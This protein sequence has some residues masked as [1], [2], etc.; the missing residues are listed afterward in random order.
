MR[1]KQKVCVE[2]WE[3]APQVNPEVPDL[4]AYGLCSS[5]YTVILAVIL[6]VPFRSKYLSSCNRRP[7]L[8]KLRLAIAHYGVFFALVYFWRHPLG[9][10]RGYI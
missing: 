6:N 10:T 2:R 9:R 3:L 8:L 1:Q 7:L 4:R 5:G